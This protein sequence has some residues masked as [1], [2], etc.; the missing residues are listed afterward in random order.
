[1]EWQA[2]SWRTKIC[3]PCLSTRASN[4]PVSPRRVRAHPGHLR[5]DHHLCTDVLGATRDAVTRLRNDDSVACLL[6]E[7]DGKTGGID[8]QRVVAA[9]EDIGLEIP[10]FLLAPGDDLGREQH[11]LLAD[12]V[13]G[14]IY[15]EEGAVSTGNQ[16]MARRGRA[17]G[18]GVRYTCPTGATVP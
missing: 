18:T 9:I 6:L 13:R 3:P 12:A 7:W 14:L 2:S 17:L 1:M 16:R 5:D 8:G 15:R 10:V 4:V 11:G